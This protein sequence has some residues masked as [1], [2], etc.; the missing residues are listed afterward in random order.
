[1]TSNF[2]PR[3]VGNAGGE[4]ELFNESAAPLEV[5]RDLLDL[6]AQALLDKE[7]LTVADLQTL[8]S[9]STTKPSLAVAAA[10]NR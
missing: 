2:H 3:R 10:A 7:T 8:L 9:S 1:M 5:R 6:A 4:L